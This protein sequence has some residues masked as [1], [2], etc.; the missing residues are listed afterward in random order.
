[1]L[2]PGAHADK[3]FVQVA[4][5]SQFAPLLEAGVEIF[6]FQTSMLHAK[7][8]TIDGL[9]ANVGSANFN[10]R[11]IT[12]D[13]EVNLVAL[14]PTLC[15][16]LDRQFENDLDQSIR[17]EEGRWEHRPLAQRALER[18]VVPVRRVF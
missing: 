13:E 8:M 17:L 6:S 4:G 7:I 2:L 16:E 18:A 1:V 9:V 11:S 12:H 14:D 10:S 5:E 3:R 15:G